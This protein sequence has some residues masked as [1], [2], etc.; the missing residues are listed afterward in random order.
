MLKLNPMNENENTIKNNKSVKRLL[1][2]FLWLLLIPATYVLVQLANDNPSFV[3]K[4]YS[5]A[6]F[7]GVSAILPFQ[8]FPFVSF[9][10]I[11]LLFGPITLLVCL[12]VFIVRI[13]KNKPNRS[14]RIVKV[15]RNFLIVLAVAY[16]LFYLLWGFNYSR[17]SYGEIARLPVQKSSTEELKVLCQSLIERTN[18][19]RSRL[20]SADDNTLE[21]PLSTS[22]LQSI[23]KNAY[24]KATKDS[25]PG[26]FTT[27]ASPK[28]LKISRFVSYTGITGIYIPY[29]AESNYNNAIPMPSIGS[30]ICHE[31]A[32][33]QGFAR[34]DEAN[35]ISYLVCINSSNDYLNYSGLLL[36]TINSMNMLYAN[37]QDS[38]RELYSLYSEE[39]LADLKKNRFYWQEHSGAVEETFT[40]LNDS[41]L[42]GNNLPDGVKSYGRMVDLLLALQRQE[43]Q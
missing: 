23:T 4:V 14:W 37:D 20:P 24:K 28:P 34:E 13:I 33:R 15:I 22:E 32:H 40:N 9:F 25:I 38:H 27:L 26:I 19:A 2:G 3:E 6:I 10:E 41:Y 39:V 7:K 5:G 11:I 31:L 12:I 17:M 35:F 16:F 36:A 21:L 42:K 8:Y 30:T 1:P 18:E 43:N 29:T